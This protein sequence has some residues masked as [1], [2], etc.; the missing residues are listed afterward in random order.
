MLQDGL[1]C[2]RKLSGSKMHSNLR[3]IFSSAALRAAQSDGI[4]VTGTH[5][6]ILR[7]FAPRGVH[8]H[9]ASMGMKFHP[10]QCN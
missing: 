8:V 1:F 2:I 9:V 10:H 4:Q 6:V 3:F 5:M 7:I